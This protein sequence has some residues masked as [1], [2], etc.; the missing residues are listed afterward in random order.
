MNGISSV[1]LGHNPRL[2]IYRR[3]KILVQMTALRLSVSTDLALINYVPSVGHDQEIT[4]Y[5]F[6]CGASASSVRM[7]CMSFRP[8]LAIHCNPP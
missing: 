1:E 6:Q 3:H 2:V 4:V 8:Y 7:Q 5:A